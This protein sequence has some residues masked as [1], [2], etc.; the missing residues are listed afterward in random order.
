M[1]CRDARPRSCPND[2]VEA[3]VHL[4]FLDDLLAAGVVLPV[5]RAHDLVD[6]GVREI[7]EEFQP[8]QQAELLL[9]VHARV[10]LP[11]LLVHA[12]QFGGEIQ[13]GSDSGARG[14]FCIATA[15]TFSISSG[16]SR[17]QR[18]NRRRRRIDD[19]VQQLGEVAGA[20]RA[21]AGQQFIHDRA[22]RIQ[23]RAVGQIQAL[24]LLGRHVARRAGDAL[25]ARN[26]RAGHQRDAEV[27]DAHVA[28]GREHD[29]RGLDVAMNHAARVRVVQRLGALEHDFDHIIEAQ[30]VVGAAVG[31]QRARAVHVLGDDVA[32]AVLFAG[33]VDRQDVRMV[34]HADHVR[35][36]QEHLA[37]DARALVI[38]AGIDVVDLDGDVA[39]V[40]RIVRQVDDAGA[41]AADFIDDEVLAD[42]LRN[43]VRDGGAF[44][45]GTAIQA[46]AVKKPAA[47]ISAAV[48]GRSVIPIA[49]R[50][51]IRRYEIPLAPARPRPRRRTSAAEV[52]KAQSRELHH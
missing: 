45:A 21:H 7:V 15:T 11:Q 28:V 5:A 34:Q 35:F 42:A 29:V 33:I 44:D 39:S 16:T 40:V 31:R 26:I 51:A 20:K 18:V 8:T 10:L 13:P 52:I 19:L 38:A 37:R 9:L 49:D 36:G 1:A 12:R 46:E 50:R 4:A 32:V 2:D 17:A 27:D 48:A 41:A 24:H 14:S 43:I 30:Q 6:L 25:D 3:I 23:I 22:E 47:R